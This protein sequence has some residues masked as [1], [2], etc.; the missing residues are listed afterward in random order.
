MWSWRQ[1]ENPSRAVAFWT[2]WSLSIKC[3]G[4]PASKALPLSRRDSTRMTISNGVTGCLMV[5][6]KAAGNSSEDVSTWIGQR[7]Y[8]CRGCRLTWEVRPGCYLTVSWYVGSWR[9]RW[10]DVR[11]DT[12]DLRAL[13]GRRDGQLNQAHRTETKKNSGKLNAKTE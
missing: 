2:D 9:W 11:Y 7:W 4:G 6:G 8:W 12:V 10:D 5:Y 1:A 3:C 13:K